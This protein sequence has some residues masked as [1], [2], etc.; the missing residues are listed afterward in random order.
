MN[1]NN[2]KVGQRVQVSCWS[3][4]YRFGTINYINMDIKNGRAGIDYT[5]DK[6]GEWW[7]YLDQIVG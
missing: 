4:E 6:G 2:L 1:I 7:C 3:G 5:D